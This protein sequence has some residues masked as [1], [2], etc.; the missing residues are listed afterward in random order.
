MLVYSDHDQR[1]DTTADRGT[2][3]RS[4]A[5]C[6]GL[7]FGEDNTGRSK[8]RAAGES[9]GDG[10]GPADRLDLPKAQEAAGPVIPTP[11]QVR[12][13]CRKLRSDPKR[14]PTT[15]QDALL[16]TAAQN[17]IEE[18]LAIETML[19]CHNGLVLKMAGRLSRGSNY[20][21]AIQAGKMGLVKAIR[22]FEVERGHRFSTYAIHW[23]ASTMRRV[24]VQGNFQAHIPEHSLYRWL[25]IRRYFNHHIEQHGT[26]PE[27]EQIAEALGIEVAEVK[28]SMGIGRM[29]PFSFESLQPKGIDP[30]SMRNIPTSPSPEAQVV[31]RTEIDRLH[32]ALEQ[33]TEGQRIAIIEYFGLDGQP[34]S[35]REVGERHGVSSQAINCRISIACRVLKKALQ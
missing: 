24:T 1:I 18:D 14:I 7:A 4:P 5:Q 20:E 26:A 31:E 17:G 19:W 8:P 9:H 23:I 27:E 21:D 33:L 35:M 32:E 2:D 29:E 28:D 30:D 34:R 10:S 6:L 16:C 25:R 22:M 15:A 13:L 12:V 3:G 11:A